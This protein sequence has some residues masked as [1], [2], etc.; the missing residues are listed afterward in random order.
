MGKILV[1]I[2]IVVL[3]FAYVR[4]KDRLA[5]ER[6]KTHN[7]EA[8]YDTTRLILRD[9]SKT[10]TERLAFQQTE[11][12][13]LEGE[14]DRLLRVEGSRVIALQRLRV[15]LDSVRG[16][17]TV[18]DVTGDSA[19]RYLT[20]RLDTLGFS[21]RI[22]ADV[23]APPAQARVEWDVSRN[24]VEVVTAL[25]RS[26]DG[27][28]ALRALTDGNATVHIDTVRM[29]VESGLKRTQS[30][31]AKLLLILGGIVIGRVLL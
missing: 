14:R 20:A 25:N 18:G 11:A 9:S 23:P 8:L 29:E 6:I 17:V 13:R 24:P 31:A 27:R 1:A 15:E 16:V 4:E 28:L 21:A 26:P 2:L 19:L 22:R 3:A 5:K 30:L 10:L 7:A 12:I